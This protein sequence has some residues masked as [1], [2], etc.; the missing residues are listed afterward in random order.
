MSKSHIKTIILITLIFLANACA[1]SLIP[2]SPTLGK[3]VIAAPTAPVI[4]VWLAILSSIV[5]MLAQS[6]LVGKTDSN[7]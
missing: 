3:L 2:V 7:V 4:W 1:L 5:W 6:I